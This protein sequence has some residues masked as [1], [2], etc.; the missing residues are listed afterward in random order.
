MRKAHLK[1]ESQTVEAILS[2]RMVDYGSLVSSYSD[3]VKSERIDWRATVLYCAET[4][5]KE[6][7]QLSGRK[8]YEENKEAEMIIVSGVIE[9]L[10]ISLNLLQRCFSEK[11]P[12]F[13]EGVNGLKEIEIDAKR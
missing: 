11:F 9:S 4:T 7:Q 10:R 1:K 6:V 13:F 2:K 3:D 12:E 5:M 8:G